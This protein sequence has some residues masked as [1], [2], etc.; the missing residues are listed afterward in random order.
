MFEPLTRPHA[1]IDTAARTVEESVSA[2]ELAT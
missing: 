2:L 1:V